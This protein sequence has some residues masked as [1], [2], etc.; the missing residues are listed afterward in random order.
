MKKPVIGIV[1]LVDIERNSY[2]MLPGYMKGIEEAG[3]I[4]V[5]LPLTS[6]REAL[7]Q[8]VRLFDGFLFSGGHD[9]SPSVYGQTPSGKCETCCAERDE[10]EKILLELAWEEDKSILGICRG[11]QFI[12]AAMGGTLYQDLEEE[13]PSSIS[14]RQSPPYDKPSHSVSVDGDTPLYDML[15]TPSLM[16]NSCH[17]QAVRELAPALRVMAVSDDG[18]AEA[19]YAP[20]KTFVWGVQWH[21]EFSHPV[22]ENSRKI[23]K[24][25]V[26]SAAP[27]SRNGD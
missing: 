26:D 13:H 17:H 5:M 7:G 10:M 20:E 1:P 14:H 4:P 8:M 11:L 25:F 23:F 3:G 19:V 21:P 27:D 12:N 24:R 16:V 6:D 22:D 2:W 18:L 15:G 9:V